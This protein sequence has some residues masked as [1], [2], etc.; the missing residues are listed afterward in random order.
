M[1]HSDRRRRRP[2]AWSPA[3]IEKAVQWWERRQPGDVAELPAAEGD[4]AGAE[5][6]TRAEADQTQGAAPPDQA[7]Q[8]PAPEP[9]EAPA[10]P[11]PDQGRSPAVPAHLSVH[12]EYL[13]CM[14]CGDRHR[15]LTAHLDEVHA[16]TPQ[17]YRRRWNLT[18]DYSMQC[19][20]DRF[21]RR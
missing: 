4:T 19:P 9:A 15:D 7:M 10:A 1:H 8:G 17:G 16:L 14:E 21:R 2:R 6:R 20:W 11:A 13:T 3:D 12:S 5:D 18:D